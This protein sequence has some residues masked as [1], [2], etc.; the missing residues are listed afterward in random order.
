MA[1]LVVLAWVF[2]TGPAQAQTPS[3]PYATLRLESILAVDVNRVCEAAVPWSERGFRML[4][5]LTDARDPTENAWF[6]RIDR[7]EADAG[8][9]DLS[10]ADFIATG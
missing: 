7:V 5:Y 3:C 4:I 8:L 2:T 6:E 1:L 10:Q 9:R